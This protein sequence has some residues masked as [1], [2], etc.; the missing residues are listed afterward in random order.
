MTVLVYLRKIPRFDLLRSFTGYDLISRAK[1]GTPP[2][3]LNRNN[4]FALKIETFYI[5]QFSNKTKNKSNLYKF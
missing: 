5:A 3:I 2:T 1:P 4:K